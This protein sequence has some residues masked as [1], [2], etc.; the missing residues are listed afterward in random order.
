[1]PPPAPGRL[2]TEPQLALSLL[3]RP[4]AAVARRYAKQKYFMKRCGL[5]QCIYLLEGDAQDDSNFSIEQK[6][7]A[8]KTSLYHTEITDGFH[9]LRTTNNKGARARCESPEP[10]RRFADYWHGARARF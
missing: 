6:Q 4:A 8:V 9:L 3:S 7:K 2:V 1:M 10:P 5:Q